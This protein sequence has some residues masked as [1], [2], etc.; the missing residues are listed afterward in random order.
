LNVKR[1]ALFFVL[2]F[3]PGL[4]HAK[5]YLLL[6]E[7]LK[8]S[9]T[10][11]TIYK[12]VPLTNATEVELLY[13]QGFMKDQ[14][15]AAFTTR[16]K[17]DDR[18]MYIGAD[19]WP[20]DKYVDELV[21]SRSW[22]E[23]LGKISFLIES[24]APDYARMP[25]GL[26]PR[27]ELWKKYAELTHTKHA[28]FFSTH[29]LDTSQ[30]ELQNSKWKNFIC[31]HESGRELKPGK[32]SPLS[33]AQNR[34]QLS[35]RQ[36]KQLDFVGAL[37]CIN[38]PK[39]DAIF[40]VHTAK[41]DAVIEADSGRF[42]L[43]NEAQS[44]K[45]RV[46]S[47]RQITAPLAVE[48]RPEVNQSQT[49]FFFQ[50]ERITCTLNRCRR[51]DARF[52]LPQFRDFNENFEFAI[53]ASGDSYFRGTLRLM[54]GEIEIA[55][56]EFRFTPQSWVA[57]TS[58]AL[59]NPSEYQ[60][61]FLIILILCIAAAGLVM[62]AWFGLKN[63]AAS[64][65]EKNAQEIP[66]QSSASVVIAQGVTY[67]MTAG[68]NPFGCELYAFG[69]IVTLAVEGDA[70]TVRH[71]GAGEKRLPLHNF[72]YDLPDGYRLEI[73]A[74]PDGQLLLTAYLLELTAAHETAI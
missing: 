59:K 51:K 41:T 42:S 56:T 49:E 20:D 69:G 26:F 66:R 54:A 37:V 22:P 38:T 17:G 29:Y 28:G 47:A 73:R 10:E 67:R 68:E 53:R 65:A 6:D 62:L 19:S 1:T 30:N 45:V 13:V 8:K 43:W 18:G 35:F 5:L 48:I 60:S 70:V 15:A 71:G 52:L 11:Q 4:A 34:F 16:L 24:N 21:Q 39:A 61:A 33:I 3:A 72:R 74:L 63:L 12:F 46:T 31:I 32:N 64:L 50:G 57:E 25:K 36:A 14:S 55:R 27:R 58:Y 23:T 2:L 7:R 44:L 40:E 9:R